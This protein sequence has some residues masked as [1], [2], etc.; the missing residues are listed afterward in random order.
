MSIGHIGLWTFFL[1]FMQNGN[2]GCMKFDFVTD[3]IPPK[4]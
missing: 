3:K 1:G 4:H 2:Q